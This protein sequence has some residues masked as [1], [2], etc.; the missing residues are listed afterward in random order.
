MQTARILK[1][2]LA[3]ISLVS[4]LLCITISLSTGAT[5]RINEAHGGGPVLLDLVR[6][7]GLEN[8]LF[9]CGRG[10]GIHLEPGN[11]RRYRHLAAGVVCLQ[12][13]EALLA[14]SNQ[15]PL[16]DHRMYYWRGSTGWW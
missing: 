11:C 6:C 1:F 9:D 3:I 8:A 13:E 2:R 16:L 5:P 14:E 4:L 12:G 10:Y 15:Y 7:N